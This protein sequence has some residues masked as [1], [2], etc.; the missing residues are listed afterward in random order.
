MTDLGPGIAAILKVCLDLPR[1]R[2]SE[3]R[4][5]A[6]RLLAS[7]EAGESPES[8]RM[9]VAKIQMA[10]GDAINDPACQDVVAQV[11]AL[12]AKHSS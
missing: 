8:L 4:E 9:Q 12:A 3:I 10:L 11:C 5:H 2:D 6:D 7:I 1:S